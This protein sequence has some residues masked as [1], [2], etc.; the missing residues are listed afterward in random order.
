METI[1][2]DIFS[3]VRSMHDALKK[4]TRVD[5]IMLPNL[6]RYQASLNAPDIGKNH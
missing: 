1:H 5:A 4:V 6:K 2:K 3:V